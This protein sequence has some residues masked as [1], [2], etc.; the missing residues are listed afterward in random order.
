M[1]DTRSVNLSHEIIHVNFEGW[2]R[3]DILYKLHFILLLP[4][5]LR[6]SGLQILSLV[7]SS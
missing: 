5:H 6:C 4:E 2:S 1:D 3:A 7:I